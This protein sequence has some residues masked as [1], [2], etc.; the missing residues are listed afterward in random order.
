MLHEGDESR[1]NRRG[2]RKEEKGSGEK[3]KED[4]RLRQCEKEDEERDGN[5]TEQAEKSEEHS[6]RLLLPLLDEEVQRLNIS[7]TQHECRVRAE[8]SRSTRG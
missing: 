4:G 6:W 3:A 7:A 5:A 1:D 2:D 8:Q